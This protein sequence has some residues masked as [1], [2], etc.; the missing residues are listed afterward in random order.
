MRLISVATTRAALL[1]L[2]LSG[3]SDDSGDTAAQPPSSGVTGPRAGLWLSGDLH[4]HSDHSDDAA[5]NPM[6]EIVKVAEDRG[7]GFFVVT[8]HDNHVEGHITTWDDPAY[9]SDKMVMLYG[10][11]YTTARGHASIVGTRRF[12]DMPMYALRD[13]SDA[14]AGRAIAAAAHRQGLHLSVNHPVNG[15]PWEFGFDMPYDSMEVWNALYAFPTDNAGAIALWDRLIAEGRRVTARG[16]SDCHHQTG[17]ES[18]GLNVGNPTTWVYATAQTPAAVLAALKDGKVSIGYAPTAERIELAADTDD[19]GGFE[20]LMGDTRPAMGKTVKFRISI[21]GARP[22][23]RYAVTVLKN[24]E[25]FMERQLFGEPTLDFEDTPAAGQRSWYRVEVRG[26]T[27][28]APLLAT[29]AGF[30]G[31]FVGLTNPLY[32]G[33]E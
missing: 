32:F 13:R 10:V 27:P 18:L 15:D 1:A 11:E 2:M 4:L 30:Y 9:R 5:D 33:F 26:D 20:T 22:L 19:D 23:G 7:M 17:I 3:C 12:D 25:P 6:A 16:G 14:D 31:G 24:G 28:E 29:L 21:A 8:D